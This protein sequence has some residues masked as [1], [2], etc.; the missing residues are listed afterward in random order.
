MSKPVPARTD[1]TPASG[2]P[3][4]SGAA[5]GL[6]EDGLLAQLGGRHF[7]QETVCEFY[8][9]IGK[10]LV[11]EDCMDHGKQRTR[12]AQFLSHALSDQPEPL[13]SARAS[14]LARGMNPALFEALLEYFEGR[15]LELGFPAAICDR[16][17]RTASHLY[18]N[19]QEPLSIAC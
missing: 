6:V 5:S 4:S 18:D 11:A 2:H 7:I 8:H 13:R 3:P 12:Q 15:L 17:V 16:V 1:F 9:A 14:F 19:S 10:H